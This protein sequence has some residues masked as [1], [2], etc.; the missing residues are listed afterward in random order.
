MLIL[1]RRTGEAVL[2]GDT[3]KVHVVSVKGSQVRLGIDAPM[4]VPVHREEVSERI[5]LEGA[6]VERAGGAR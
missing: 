5:R 6:A 1:T 4:D 3:I 2:I